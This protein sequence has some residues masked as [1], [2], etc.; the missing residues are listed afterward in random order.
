MFKSACRARRCL[1]PIDG[2]SEWKDIFGNAKNKQPYAIAMNSGAPF[3]LAGI[4]ETFRDQAGIEIRYFAI[5]TSPASE[6][7]AATC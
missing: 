7:M 3:A 1:V 4:R 2:S 6:M 5:V